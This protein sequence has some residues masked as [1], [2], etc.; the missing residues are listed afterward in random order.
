MKPS[1]STEW[2]CDTSVELALGQ[3]CRHVLE[4]AELLPRRPER[5]LDGLRVQGPGFRVQGAGFGVPGTGFRVQGTEFRVQGTGYRGQGSGFKVQ[6]EILPGRPESNL[7]GCH[8][9]SGFG[10][11][12][13]SFGHG[14]QVSGFGFRVWCQVSGI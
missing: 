10:L 2:V 11:W 7:E 14:C 12:V 3:H 9:G 4:N 6:G 13:S 5:N 8:G 1:Y